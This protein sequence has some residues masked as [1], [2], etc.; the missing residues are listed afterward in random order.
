VWKIEGLERSNDCKEIV[1]MAHRDG[2]NSVGC[3]VLGRGEDTEKVS[4][5]LKTA[6]RVAGFI[7]F[8]VGRTLFWDPLIDWRAQKTNRA[9]TVAEI[10]RRYRAFVDIFETA[11]KSRAQTA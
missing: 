11:C 5:W 7:G 6:A 10:A 8:A 2:R 9:A 4:E 1:A 3:I